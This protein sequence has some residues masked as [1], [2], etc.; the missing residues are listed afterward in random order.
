MKLRR[1]LR[2]IFLSLITEP[3]EIDLEKLG[4]NERISKKLQYGI[5]KS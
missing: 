2:K 3:G 1:R 5:S 4:L